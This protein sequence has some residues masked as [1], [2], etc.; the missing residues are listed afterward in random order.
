[1]YRFAFS[2]LVPVVEV[3]VLHSTTL[4][5]TRRPLKGYQIHLGVNGFSLLQ[6]QP[7]FHLKRDSS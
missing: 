4:N 5:P 6:T 3:L 7:F 1:M 2:L